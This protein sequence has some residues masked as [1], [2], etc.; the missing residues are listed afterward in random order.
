MGMV[1]NLFS[2]NTLLERKESRIGKRPIDIPK[3]VNVT[4]DQNRITA[5]GPCGERSLNIN[6]ALTAVHNANQIVISKRNNDRETRKLHGL[7]RTL[8]NNM[9]I[10]VA[11]AF[12]KKLSLSGVGYRAKVAD[13][14]L[15][16]S[17][18]FTHDVIVDLPDSID[19]SVSQN[20][21][22]T[23]RGNDKAEVGNFAATLRGIRPPE[24]YG[25][26]GVRYA[27]EVVKLK[28]GKSG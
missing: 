18:G 3:C 8:L 1:Q 2:L 4:L 16:L 5:K 11:D 10:G 25:G 23:V 6:T 19:V 26:K 13:R 12:E 27:N 24:P 9:I 28:E 20:V 17:V 14:K 22:L 21:N 7:N 15:T